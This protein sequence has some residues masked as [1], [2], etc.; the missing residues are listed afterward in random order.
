MFLSH[1][2][3]VIKVIMMEQY[4]LLAEAILPKDMLDWFDFKKVEVEEVGGK[5]VLHF[6]LDE[7]ELTPDG[8]ADLRP[9]GFTRESVFHDFPI[10]GRETTPFYW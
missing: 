8:K 7:N 4:R 10:H 1:L 9:N 2:F 3:D 5:T 6:Y